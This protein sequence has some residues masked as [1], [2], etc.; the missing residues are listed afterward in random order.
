MPNMVRKR[1][2]QS[3]RTGKSSL[4]IEF[5]DELLALI[6]KVAD[7]D[8]RSVAFIVRKACMFWLRESPEAV[9]LLSDATTTPEEA[10]TR[11]RD[12]RLAAS[13]A[14]FESDS[15]TQEQVEAASVSVKE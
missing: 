13:V 2:K 11:I 8:E 7:K 1:R 4:A 3:V 12:N 5:P 14:Q 9:H 10:L 6:R 15:R